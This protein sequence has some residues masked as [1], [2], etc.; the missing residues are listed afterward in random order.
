VSESAF[1]LEGN[2]FH[3]QPA[4]RAR[5]YDEAL[6]GGPVAALFARQVERVESSQPMM[7][8][9]LTVD[10]MRP[11]PT[12][13]ITVATRVLR[14]G[15]RIQV[16]DATMESDGVDVARASALRMR[17]G[18]IEG[19]PEHPRRPAHAGPEGL[20]KAVWRGDDDG[21]WFHS[22]AV[23]MRFVEGG[24][25]EAGPATAWMRMTLPL[26]EGEDPSPLQQVAALSD[27]GN[28]LSRVLASGWWFI[29]ADLTVYLERYP[30][31]DWMLLRSRTDIDHAGTGLAQSELFDRRGSIGHALQ[32]LFVDRADR[33]QRGP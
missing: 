13:P 24:F 22:H 11:V 7:V 18:D 32:S 31:S 8:T 23:D 12:K 5:W 20:E 28:G 14:E 3:P 17:L 21:I 19:L 26:V 10:L 25:Y 15:R 27:F 33:S 29:N 2:R 6:H 30:E 1:T 4:S 16:I 9:R